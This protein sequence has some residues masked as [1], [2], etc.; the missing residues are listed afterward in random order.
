VLGERG[1][2]LRGADRRR[3]DRAAVLVD[4][5]PSSPPGR[6]GEPT[7]VVERVERRRRRE[8]RQ[9]D[10]G[11]SRARRSL[12]PL[13]ATTWAMLAAASGSGSAYS[14]SSS[15]VTTRCRPA[16]MS[17]AARNAK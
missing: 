12:L 6:A 5:A 9:P 8:R 16:T 2:E 3:R 17:A 7:E 13:S 1:E 14:P 11:R 4:E 10:G 15:S